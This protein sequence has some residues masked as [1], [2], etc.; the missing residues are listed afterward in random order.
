VFSTDSALARISASWSVVGTP[1][2]DR[3]TTEALVRASHAHG[4]LAI[5]HIESTDDV[6]IAVESGVDGLAHVWRQGGPA[7]EI[8]ELVARRNVFVI[9]TLATP[10]GFVLGSGT[11]LADDPRLELLVTAGLTPEQARTAAT[12]R[13]AT[14]FRLEDRGKVA[15]GCRA[16]LVLVRGDPTRDITATRDI[17]KV[18]RSGVEF[19]RRLDVHQVPKPSPSGDLSRRLSP[20][21]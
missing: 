17:L 12:E 2:L 3:A 19:D 8:A 21:R 5:A 9:P 16:D 4:L 11:T 10:D 1:T 7:P 15:P 18:W 14:I 13:V 6:R 20:C